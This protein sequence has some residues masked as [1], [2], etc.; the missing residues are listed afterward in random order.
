MA[1][2]SGTSLGD[3]VERIL[4]TSDRR[5]VS[6]TQALSFLVMLLVAT[7]WI[8]AVRVPAPSVVRVLEGPGDEDGARLL[9]ENVLVKVLIDLP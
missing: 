2:A 3:R 4:G 9:G 8:P 7:A 5:P 1:G 6:R